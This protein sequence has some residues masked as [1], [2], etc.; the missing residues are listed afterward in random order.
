VSGPSGIAPGAGYPG[1]RTE[2]LALADRLV[3]LEQ[4][5]AKRGPECAAAR[6]RIA[7]ATEEVLETFKLLRAL[8]DRQKGAKR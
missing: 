5:L 7:A 1:A 6:K 2:L 8:K 3:T 4:W